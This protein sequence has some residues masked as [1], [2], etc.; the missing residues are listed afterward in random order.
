MPKTKEELKDEASLN[1]IKKVVKTMGFVLVLGTI[2]LIVA[3]I[4][5]ASSNKDG[6]HSSKARNNPQECIAKV[7]QIP[8][9]GNVLSA[10]THKNRLTVIADTINAGQQVLIIDVCSGDVLS[11]FE[12]GRE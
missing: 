6:D 12:F 10:T 2:A 5:K 8:L 3:V 9:D 7:A 1:R 4:Y 11:R